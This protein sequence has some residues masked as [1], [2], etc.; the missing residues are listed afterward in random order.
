[1]RNPTA[2]IARLVSR[3]PGQRSRISDQL[4][5]VLPVTLKESERIGSDGAWRVSPDGSARTRLRFGLTS[6]L[7]R[8]ELRDLCELLVIC[9]GE[10]VDELTDLLG[11]LTTDR[12]VHVVSE[13]AIC[14]DV[15][16]MVDPNTGAIRGW[17]VQQMIKLAVA[18]QVRTPFYLTLDSDIVCI[19][20]FSSAD[21]ITRGRG[22]CGTET[23]ETYRHLYTPKF[24]ARETMIKRTRMEA[25]A[26]LL[27]YERDEGCAG[28]FYSETPVLYHAETMRGMLSHLSATHG[29]AWPEVL[30]GA[31]DWTEMALYF[32][33]LE[34]VG[35][36]EQ[37]Y[38]LAGPNRVLHLE[39]SV[40]QVNERYRESRS[41][42]AAHFERLVAGDEGLFVA[43]QSWLDTDGWLPATGV[44]SL[45]AFY[46]LLGEALGDARDR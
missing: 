10:E 24:A 17:Y 15:V 11:T 7:S 37:R 34:M 43:I 8:F 6:L 2:Y 40:W 31:E 39:G 22:V 30:A 32:S 14:P 19:R 9:P 42:N 46:G 41:Y 36:L 20:Q 3:L 28:R 16:R 12:R 1:M 45:E 35:E 29:K 18:Q 27:G 23:E 33:Y 21:L 44:G 38:E 25:S 4:T 5:F 26:A 13:T